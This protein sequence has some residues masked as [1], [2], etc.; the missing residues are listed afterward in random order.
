MEYTFSWGSFFFGLII[1]GLGVALTLWYQQIADAVGGGVSSYDRYRLTG[2]I[3]CALGA[4]VMLNLHT[5]ILGS[6]FS[7]VFSRG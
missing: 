5:F 4:I 6:L 1:L 7:S 2:L 3:C